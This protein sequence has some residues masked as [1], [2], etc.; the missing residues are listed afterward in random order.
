MATLTRAGQGRVTAQPS[1]PN[2]PREAVGGDRQTGVLLATS[3]P[4]MDY[5]K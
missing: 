2:S 5:N 4:I 1:T 3:A